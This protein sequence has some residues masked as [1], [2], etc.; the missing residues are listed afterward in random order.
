V[1]VELIHLSDILGYKPRIGVDDSLDNLVTSL[2]TNGQMSPIRVRRHPVL[3]GKYEIVY[4]NRRFAA[5]K[6]LGWQSI[7]AVVVTASDTEALLLAITENIDRK[8]FCDYEKALLFREL[9]QKSGKSYAEIGQLVGR[10][11]AY[12]SQHLSMLR[13]FSDNVASKEEIERVLLSLTERHCRCLLK[14][15]NELERW[16][17]ARFAVNAKMAPRELERYCARF[18]NRSSP[19]HDPKEHIRKLITNALTRQNSKDL[20]P[21]FETL[22]SRDSGIFLSRWPPLRIMDTKSY[23]EHVIN[24][25]HG[26]DSFKEA[27]EDMYIRILGKMAYVVVLS[28]CDISMANHRKIEAK[29]RITF[30][31]EREKEWKIVHGHW[32]SGTP[33]HLPSPFENEEAPSL[34]T[35]FQRSTSSEL[36]HTGQEFE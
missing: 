19:L 21:L 7:S 13:L 15:E 6:K 1:S 29:I 20:G 36:Y 25:H 4:G 16:N 28:N 8:D 27:I 31:L 11:S 18:P 32:S 33:D 10:S 24:F 9:W 34:P 22:S 2:N 12:I 17:N 23:K 30:I 14:I 3:Q 5:A 26:V 35:I